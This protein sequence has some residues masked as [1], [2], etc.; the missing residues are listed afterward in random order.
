MILL[1][2]M[3]IIICYDKNKLNAFENYLQNFNKNKFPNLLKPSLGIKEMILNILEKGDKLQYLQEKKNDIKPYN[4]SLSTYNIQ[5]SNL[6]NQ[7]NLFKPYEANINN[8]SPPILK[9]ELY[10]SEEKIINNKSKLSKEN[11]KNIYNK[12]KNILNN[13]KNIFINK[14]ENKNENNFDLFSTNSYLR[15]IEKQ[16]RVHHPT[17][18]YSSNYN[19]IIEEIGG[20]LEKLS[21]KI[22]KDKK[23]KIRSFI[24]PQNKYKTNSNNNNFKFITQSLNKSIEDI[25]ITSNKTFS[26]SNSLQQ[27]K[28][29][30][31]TNSFRD[32]GKNLILKDFKSLNHKNEMKINKKLNK[33]NLSFNKIRRKTRKKMTRIIINKL[34][35]KPKLNKIEIDDVKKRLKLTEYIVY[36]NAK[37]KLMLEE[38]GKNELYEFNKFKHN[39]K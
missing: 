13:K 9:Q 39:L 31:N 32:R 24:K 5:S 21:K 18:N 34:N 15:Y 25:F 11:D 19:L 6:I 26:H 16:N 4:N 10:S 7:K 12:D 8:K 20:E 35:L 30:E 17:K 23:Y 14:K 2:L 22:K 37:R 38:L 1:L 28:N 29:L 36:N 27:K 33:N 3:H